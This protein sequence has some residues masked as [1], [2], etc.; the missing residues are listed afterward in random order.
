MWVKKNKIKLI[1]E[2]IDNK[3]KIQR[4]DEII[5][6]LK[7]FLNFECKYYI[8]EF[9]NRIKKEFKSESFF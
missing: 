1:N 2:K 7:K 6:W 8:D 3:F 9:L 4:I 5:I